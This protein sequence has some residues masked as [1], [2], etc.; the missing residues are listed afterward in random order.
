MEPINSEVSQSSGSMLVDDRLKDGDV[1]G[2]T[3]MPNQSNSG[4]RMDILGLNHAGMMKQ[5]LQNMNRAKALHRQ[6]SVDIDMD[7]SNSENDEIFAAKEPE[8]VMDFQQYLQQQKRLKRLSRKQGVIDKKTTE[9]MSEYDKTGNVDSACEM[10][11]FEE[12]DYYNDEEMHVNHA[13][14]DTGSVQ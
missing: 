10:E 13:G 2:A 12:E 9:F 4:M 5:V 1:T 6:N 11:D 8:G 7:V 3:V 14:D